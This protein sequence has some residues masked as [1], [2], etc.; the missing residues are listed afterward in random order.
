MPK[1]SRSPSLLRDVGAI[2]GLYVD[3]FRLME[4]RATGHSLIVKFEPPEEQP[5]PD[6]AHDEI[7]T[8][9]CSREEVH[10]GR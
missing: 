7:S 2:A 5:L 6:A 8:S 3:L 9:A 1:S 10:A 4:K